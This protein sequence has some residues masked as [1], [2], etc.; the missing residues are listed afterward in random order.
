MKKNSYNAKNSLSLYFNKINNIP[1]LS[2]EEEKKLI[3]EA[4]KGNKESFSKL[5]ISNQRLVIREALRYYFKQDNLL[6]LINEG[7]KGLIR[8]LKRFDLS[9]DN[10]FYTYAIWWVKSEIR[11]YLSK[12]QNIIS[13]P[14][15]FYNDYL[16]FKKSKFKLGKKL[17]RKPSIKELAKDL[18]VPEKKIKV[19]LSVPDEILS[20]DK[21]IRDTNSPKLSNFIQ[22]KNA[23]DPEEIMQALALKDLLNNDIAE[24]STKEERVIKLRFGFDGNEPM[25]L[26]QIAKILEMSP[27]GIRRIETKALKKL[28]QNLMK[29]GIYGVLN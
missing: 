4:Q 19:L 27:E 14:D 11:Q 6:D 5:I 17:G 22:D 28:K 16:K 3:E 15:L 21:E 7:N 23:E 10:K 1:I 8:A 18:N 2:T 13:F 12:N 29:K 26:R 20:L 24:L 9:K 25:K